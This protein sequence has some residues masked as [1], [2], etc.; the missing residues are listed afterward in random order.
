ME[1]N[2][3]MPSLPEIDIVSLTKNPDKYY[4]EA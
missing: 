4:G 2:K 1:R 3:V